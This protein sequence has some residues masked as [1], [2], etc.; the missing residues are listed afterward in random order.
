PTLIPFSWQTSEVPTLPYANTLNTTFMNTNN[1]FHWNRQQYAALN[2][3]F[4]SSGNFNDLTVADY[5]IA[6][7]RHWLNTPDDTKAAGTLSMQREPSPDGTIRGQ[8][9]EE[10]TSELQSP[11]HLVCRLLL[12]KK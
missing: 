4:L 11:D 5:N 6:R 3:T 1:S 10:H 12:E 8:R 9:S 2:S 7:M